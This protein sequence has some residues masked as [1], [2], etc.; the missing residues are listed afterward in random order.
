[1]PS[2]PLQNPLPREP[3]IFKES[4][5]DGLMDFLLTPSSIVEDVKVVMLNPNDPH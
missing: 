4:L 5:A 1:M 3:S 2:M